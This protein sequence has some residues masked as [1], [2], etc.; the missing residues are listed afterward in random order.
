GEHAAPQLG[1]AALTTPRKF[2]D[3]LSDCLPGLA[4]AGSNFQRLA[5]VIECRRHGHQVVLERKAFGQHRDG[6]IWSIERPLWARTA[7]AQSVSQSS[8]PGMSAMLT[9]PKPAPFAGER[10]PLVPIRNK[11]PSSNRF[12]MRQQRFACARL[13]HP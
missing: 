7:G 5:H 11:S 10:I 3:A 9:M 8:T 6:R 13:S 1:G 2:D 4:V 12:S